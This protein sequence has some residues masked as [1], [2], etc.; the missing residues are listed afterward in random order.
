M[1]IQLP[2]IIETRNFVHMFIHEH[3]YSRK[4]LVGN[5]YSYHTFFVK[6]SRSLASLV[7]SY[8]GGGR[9]HGRACQRYDAV[10]MRIPWI[11]C[12]YRT[13][14]LSLS[15]SHSSLSLQGHMIISHSS[16]APTGSHL[17]YLRVTMV[18][19]VLCQPKPSL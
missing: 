16:L 14:L 1:E 8:R 13:Y 17:M 12:G 9:G 18:T 19:V 5:E 11:Q 4:I 7:R 2:D 15:M 10:T 3:V 6:V